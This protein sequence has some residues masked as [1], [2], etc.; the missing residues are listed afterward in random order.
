MRLFLGWWALKWIGT[1]SSLS[2]LVERDTV[3]RPVVDTR[4]RPVRRGPATPVVVP[5]AGAGD[6]LR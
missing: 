3:S 6:G 2:P 1:P 4:R 5:L